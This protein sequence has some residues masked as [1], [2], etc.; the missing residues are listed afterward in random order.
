MESSKVVK[1]VRGA[2]G[3]VLNML[4]LRCVVEIQVEMLGYVKLEFGERTWLELYI[5]EGDFG[6]W[7]MVFEA[8][9]LSKITEGVN[10]GRERC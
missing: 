3:L 10:A 2:N 4:S 5:W 8:M 6:I 7:H 9:K 1:A